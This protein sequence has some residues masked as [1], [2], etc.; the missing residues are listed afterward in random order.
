M[1]ASSDTRRPSIGVQAAKAPTAPH[2]FLKSRRNF[3][4]NSFDC[5][6]FP[7]YIQDAK[8]ARS[9]QGPEIYKQKER[10]G[11]SNSWTQS[12]LTTAAKS[13]RSWWKTSE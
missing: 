13:Q 7:A 1:N 3:R 10:K 8:V 2:Y 4:E 9:C 5:D 12:R 6:S 11:R